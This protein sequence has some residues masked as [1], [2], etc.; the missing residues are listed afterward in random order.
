MGKSF[1]LDNYCIHSIIYNII[2]YK[3]NSTLNLEL[4]KLNLKRN[5]MYAYKNNNYV[6]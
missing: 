2:G 3:K 4:Y 6:I 5:Q 1:K